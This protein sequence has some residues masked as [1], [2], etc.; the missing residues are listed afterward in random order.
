MRGC[1]YEGRIEHFWS[2]RSYTQGALETR[3]SGEYRIVHAQLKRSKK[4]VVIRGRN[5]NHNDDLKNT[6][7][8]AAIRAA[9]ITGPFWEFYEAPVAKGMKPPMTRLTLARS[10]PSLC[11]SEEGV[12]FDAEHL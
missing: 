7:K 2:D 8:G 5:K 11:S 12:R 9:A 10:P 3:N 6:F 1:R 4:S